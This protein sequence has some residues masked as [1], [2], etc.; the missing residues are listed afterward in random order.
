MDPSQILPPPA[1]RATP[2]P[3][4]SDQ[5]VGTHFTTPKKPGGRLKKKSKVVV[6]R[7]DLA[8]KKKVL[9]ERIHALT[10]QDDQGSSSSLD[11]TVCVTPTG[12]NVLEDLDVIMDESDDR[13]VGHGHTDIFTDSELTPTAPLIKEHAKRSSVPN[14]AS[15]RLFSTWLSLNSTLV[16]YYLT[17]LKASQRRLS[18]SPPPAEFSCPKNTCYVHQA[19]I[20]CLYFDCQYLMK[21]NWFLC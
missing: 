2:P 3:K 13:T 19:P 15:Q 4:R 9:E 16:P 21:Q 14:S 18:S 10:G 17:Y 6:S 11:V 20:L 12:E 8:L 1:S 5:L 7:P